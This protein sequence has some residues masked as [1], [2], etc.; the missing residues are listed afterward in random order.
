MPQRRRLITIFAIVFPSISAILILSFVALRVIYPAILRTTHKINRPGIDLMETV[1]I[2]GI[3]QVLYFRGQRTENPVILFL[4][5]GPGGTH[6]SFIHKYQYPLEYDFTIVNWDQRNTA[7]T[8]YANDPKVVLGTMGLQRALDDAYEVTQYVKQKLGKD[9]I[10]LLGHSWGSVLGTMMALAHPED[11]SALLCIGQ[12]TNMTDSERALYER[13]LEVVR[14]SGN[15]RDIAALEA[16]APY[17]SQIKF[18]QKANT[19]LV[20]LRGIQAKYKVVMDLDAKL[21]L[22]ATTSPYCSTREN[23]QFLFVSQLHSQGE[24]LHFLMEDF[25][26]FDYST[27]YDIPV[28]YIIGEKDWQTPFELLREYFDKISAPDKAVFFIPD[29][30]HFTILDN[31]EAFN[32]VLVEEIKPRIKY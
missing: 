1:E 14:A 23:L 9:K 15:R 28:Y 24:L 8:Y 7:K 12:P 13:T 2:G 17:S 11:Y 20:K 16:I 19:Q 4:H 18:D 5:G 27:N 10:M 26:I 6:M 32:R 3:Q 25:N 21:F 31:P 29:A 22:A 30:G